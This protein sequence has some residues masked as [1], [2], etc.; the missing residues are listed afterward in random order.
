MLI[1]RIFFAIAL[2][3]ALAWPQ[4]AHAYIDASSGAMILQMLLGGIA[5]LIVAIKFYGKQ[6]WAKITGKSR[7]PD[8]KSSPASLHRSETESDFDDRE[9]D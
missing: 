4:S 5:G 7:Q 3:G 6:V 9:P 1:L 8:S 2:G